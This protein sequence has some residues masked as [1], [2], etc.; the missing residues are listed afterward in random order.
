MKYRLIV[1][2]RIILRVEKLEKRTGEAVL[3]A[4]DLN[5]IYHQQLEEHEVCGIV[6]FGFTF[7]VI[8]FYLYII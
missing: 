5:A 3:D 2:R 7:F 1:D 8:V 6:I 4:E